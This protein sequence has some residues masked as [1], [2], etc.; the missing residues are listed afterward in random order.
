MMI[1]FVM[2]DIDFCDFCNWGLSQILNN[3]EKTWLSLSTSFTSVLVSL[4]SES[5]VK[6]LIQLLLPFLKYSKNTTGD[7]RS[8]VKYSKL[9]E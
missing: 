2:C 7:V 3:I 1:F 9:N 5:M 8:V 6:S 4:N